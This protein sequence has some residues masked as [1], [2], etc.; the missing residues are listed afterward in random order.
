MKKRAKR[1]PFFQ[2]APR[3]LLLIIGLM[4]VGLL[5]VV[6]LNE[7]ITQVKQLSYTSFLKKVEQHE[8][9]TI[10]VAGQDVWGQLTTGE[11]FE[12]LLPEGYH[13]WDF[14][15]TNNVEVNIGSPAAQWSLGL[16]LGGLFSLLAMIS[17]GIFLYR[18][19][20]NSGGGG[21]TIFSMGK[22]RARIFMP[23]TIKTKFGDIAG[24]SE[25]KEQ[26]KDVVDYLKNPEKYR[27]LGAKVTR[28]VLLVGE[29]G[30]GKTLMAKAVAGE[31]GVPF[32]SITGSDFIEVF[33]GVGASRVRDLF[34]QARKYAP[35]IIFIDEIDAIG[36]MRGSGL[37]GGH[38][39]REQTLNQLL[40]EMD[41]FETGEA[42]PLI[43]LAATN[44]PD[45]LDK[46]LLR[47][48]RFDRRVTVPFPDLKDREQILWIHA[49]SIMLDPEV[50]LGKMAAVTAGFSGSDLAN[51]VNIAAINASKANRSAVTQE[52]FEEAHKNILQSH[53]T[54]GTKT[55]AEKSVYT[56][57]MLMPA[58]MKLNFNAVAGATE[59]KEE[60][61]DVVDFLKNPEKYKRLGAQMPKGVLL[62]GEPGN[63]KT[64]LAKA[65]AGEA[66]VPFFHASG[67][68]FVEKYVGVGAARVRE[69]FVTARRHAPAII[70]MDEID[71]IGSKRMYEGGGSQE[72]SQTLNQL[73]TEL[74]GFD[75]MTAGPIIIMGAT[76]RPEVLDKALLRPGR[77][78]RQ[79]EVPYPDY[80]SRKQILELHARNKKID[81]TI[82]FDA[83]ARGTPGFTGADLAN[84]INEAVINASKLDKDM[85]TLSDFEES[86][87]RILL[88][89]ESKSK[90]LTKEEL[91]VTAYHEAGHALVR[92]LLPQHSDPLYKIT[93]IPRGRALG[94]THSLPEKESYTRDKE[95]MLASIA[96]ALG[97]RAAEE[98]VFKRLETGAASDFQAATSVARNMVVNYGMSE[99]LGLVSYSDFRY[100][101][102][103][104]IQL[105]D[106]EIRSITNQCYDRAK[107]LLHTN[108]DKLDVL[109]KRLLEKETLY[110]G[111][112]YELL[113][114]TPREQFKLS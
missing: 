43:V 74:D 38:D 46:A 101:S 1:P 19:S 31:A 73:L 24:A 81:P 56:P 63:G 104:T 111:E 76:N 25:A 84:L 30:N 96:S 105:I 61:H 88:G 7:S 23:H 98:L 64:L 85:A 12:T 42:P 100:L 37:G 16:V 97:G 113:G 32:F 80:I 69:L 22:S 62:T 17:I 27:R 54:D 45:V 11:H 87:D 107:D 60:L 18:Q 106:E 89:K 35:A 93:I 90:I 14:F 40:T 86:R 53:A 21:G 52:D 94:V 51:L 26:L 6:K 59:A 72:H 48:G 77:F 13:D 83:M 103:H 66:N 20:R 29:P 92:L 79:V 33:V 110:A 8:I 68:E 108:R 114:I 2:G 36:R 4:M 49:A 75:T 82:D 28:G 67:S 5:A 39:E 55:S 41:G 9:K 65:V 109:A 95:H 50:D 91:E 99:K 102:Q 71:A 34:A 78:D 112:I 70:F 57:K 15:K 58:Q 44:M 10:R 3:N 47:P